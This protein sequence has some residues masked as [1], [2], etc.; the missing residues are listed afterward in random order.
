MKDEIRL[1]TAV[2]ELLEAAGVADWDP[3]G[4]YAPT[5]GPAIFVQAVPEI[6]R[7]LVTL[8]TYPVAASTSPNDAVLGLQV[9]TR[10]EGEDPRPVTDLDEAVYAVLHGATNIALG[11]RRVTS[12]RLQS[13]AWLGQDAAGRWSRSANYYVTL[14]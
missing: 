4:I 13:G 9:R 10:A 2:A 7:D 11:G 14:P 8:S 6:G 1:T 5:G 12:I 3:E